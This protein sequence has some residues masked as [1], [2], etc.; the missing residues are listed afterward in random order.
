MLT[1]I[2]NYR[3]QI[4]TCIL[5]VLLLPVFVFLQEAIVSIGQYTGTALRMY[6][7]GVCIK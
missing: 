4:F 3:K 1:I 2:Q 6:V 7:E 5:V